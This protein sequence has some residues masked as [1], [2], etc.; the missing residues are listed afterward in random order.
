MV[1][2]PSLAQR[3]LL[4]AVQRK[5]EASG[6]IAHDR[7]TVVE[8]VVVYGVHGHPLL[9]VFAEQIDGGADDRVLSKEDTFMIEEM[10]FFRTMGKMKD[11]LFLHKMIYI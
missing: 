6:R 8:W 4:V 11:T 3:Q 2:S 5:D 7:E 1:S 9:W 10:C